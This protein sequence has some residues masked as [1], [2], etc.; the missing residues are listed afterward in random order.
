MNLYHAFINAQE[1]SNMTED[2]IL[3]KRNSEILMSYRTAGD[4][5][6]KRE[7]PENMTTKSESVNIKPEIY[8]R[9]YK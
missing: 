9:K 1:R 3:E 6:Y 4:S 2:E 5:I 7:I 8:K